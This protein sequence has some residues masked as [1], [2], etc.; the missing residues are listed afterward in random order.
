[1]ELM[2]QLFRQVRHRAR[3]DGLALRRACIMRGRHDEFDVA[4][5]A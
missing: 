4:D 2:I 5:E 3:T 1:M